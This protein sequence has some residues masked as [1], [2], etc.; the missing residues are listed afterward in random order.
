MSTA[1]DTELRVAQLIL[2][3]R[4]TIALTGAGISVPSGIPDF[5][6][7]EGLWS[8]YDIMEYGTIHAFKAD[9]Y[10][11]WKLLREIGDVVGS[12]APNPAHEAL[13]ELESL[14]LLQGIVTQNIDALHQRAGSRVVY[15]FHGSC[16]GFSCLCC[17]AR[18][19]K[20]DPELTRD[21]NGIPHCECTCPVKPDIVLFG[22]T[23]PQRALED[24]FHL[25]QR[26]ELVLV[27][28]TSATV[29][30]AS[31]LP[32]VVRGSGGRIVEMNLSSTE[33]SSRADLRLMG[34]V[35]VTLPALVASVRK[36][37]QQLAD[38]NP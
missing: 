34:D 26:A 21:T 17:G 28:G 18:Y 16:N 30:P 15:E 27:V 10:K 2:Q 8:R 11:V 29:A 9:P 20:D 36:L 19:R 12:A 25:A 24:S 1:P 6:S 14:G 7:P 33:L 3:S 37:Q 32:S 35:A 13:A 31:S 4:C 22:E 23:I 38:S 5:R